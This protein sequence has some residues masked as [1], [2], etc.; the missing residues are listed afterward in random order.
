MSRLFPGNQSII[1]GHALDDINGNDVEF[2][3]MLP[4][5]FC[6]EHDNR[7]VMTRRLLSNLARTCPETDLK[8]IGSKHIANLTKF[9]M[10]KQRL[11][12]A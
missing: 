10:A 6:E 12:G 9:Q 4:Q 1:P 2:A 5:A 7:F 8:T 3:V 11:S